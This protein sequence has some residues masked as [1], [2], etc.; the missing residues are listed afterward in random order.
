MNGSGWLNI[1]KTQHLI[2]LKSDLGWYFM[3]DNFTKKTV[4]IHGNPSL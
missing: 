3:A 4:I 2:V 1:V